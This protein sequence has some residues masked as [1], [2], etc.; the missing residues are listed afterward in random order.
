MICNV[1]QPLDYRNI[2][3]KARQNFSVIAKTAGLPR[4][5]AYLLPRNDMGR[6][7]AFTLAEGATP[8]KCRAELVSASSQ[9][10]SLGSAYS[11]SRNYVKVARSRNSSAYRLTH[12]HFVAVVRFVKFVMTSKKAAFTLAEGATH[13][14][15][16]VKPRRAAFTLAEVLITLGIIGVVAA[17]TLPALIQNYQKGVALNRLKQTFS[18]LQTGAEAVS[19]E[20][21]TLPMHKWSCDN[22][23]TEFDYSQES[24]FHLV[25][26]KMGAKMYERVADADKVMCYEGKPYRPY[27]NLRGA[28]LNPFSTYSWSAQMPNGAC[29]LWMAYAYTGNDRGVFYIDVDGPYSGYNTL[30]KDL[31]YFKYSRTNDGHGLGNSGW[32]LFPGSSNVDG[33]D[34][35]DVTLWNNNNIRAGCGKGRN[36]DGYTCSAKIM[37]DGWQMDRDYP[38]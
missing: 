30:G 21:D 3:K 6:K 11:E 1:I 2:N 38:W 12:P 32:M 25:P 10:D 7:A 14:A 23:G 27:K 16:S 4:S 36:S 33:A 18:Q 24:C 35:Q 34:A 28:D 37:R 19:A 15:Q 26:K 8:I 17:M 13:V 5:Q 20:F 9:C 31:F 29:V 22:G